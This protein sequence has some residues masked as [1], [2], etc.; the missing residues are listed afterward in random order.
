MHPYPLWLHRQATDAAR[1]A[2]LVNIANNNGPKFWSF[3]DYIFVHQAE[4]YNSVFY[5][6]TQQDLYNLFSGYGQQ[7]GVS[8]S[9]FF[10]QITSDPVETMVDST[11]AV[12]TGSRSISSTSERSSFTR[13]NLNWRR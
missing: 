9:T 2:S 7:F 5:T 4:F 6:K 10:A 3:V 1:L 13:S 11:I 8:N 12:F